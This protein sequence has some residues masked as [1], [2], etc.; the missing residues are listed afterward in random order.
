MRNEVWS[1]TE[2]GRS[3]VEI[4]I[5]LLLVAMATTVTLPA[6]GR[7]V[8]GAALAGQANTVAGLMMRCRARAVLRGTTVGL[9]FDRVDGGW[10]CRVVQDGDGDGIRRRD[11]AGGIDPV[12]ER[13]VELPGGGSGLGILAGVHVPSPSGHGWLDGD[14]HDPIRAGPGDIISFTRRGTASPS[15][16][17][18]S[19]G[20][21]RMRVLR[22][23]GTTGR[24]RQLRW[25]V[26]WVQ[27]RRDSW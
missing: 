16:V 17:Y 26:G 5:V 7:A 27:W 3:L 22:T 13:V 23:M 18:F 19:D 11:I 20:R 4:A 10:R 21:S 8:R 2:E 12:V 15:S 1:P 25:Q 24:T 9:V 6:L 14:P